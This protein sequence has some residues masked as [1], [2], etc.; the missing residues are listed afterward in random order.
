[1]ALSL[2]SRRDRS[3]VDL[4][5]VADGAERKRGSDGVVEAACEIAILIVSPGPLRGPRNP[6]GRERKR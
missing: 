2:L 4:I 3:F 1:M 5:L 6:G